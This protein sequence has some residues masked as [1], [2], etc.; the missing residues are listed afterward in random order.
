[1]TVESARAWVT[2]VWTAFSPSVAA[3]SLRGLK[4]CFR[5]DAKSSASTRFVA[6]ALAGVFCS[7]CVAI[8]SCPL[9]RRIVSRRLLDHLILQSRHQLRISQEL[10]QRVLGAD[11]SVHVTQQ[12]GKLLAGL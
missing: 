12:I 3:L 7:C 9:V 10:L 4:F 6:A 2:R 5:I 8:A 11:L 1:M